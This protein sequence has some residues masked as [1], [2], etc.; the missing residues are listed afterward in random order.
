MINE[1]KSAAK[2]IR[3]KKSQK[4]QI[5]FRILFLAI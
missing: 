2:A 4:N 5:I 1:E 3:K